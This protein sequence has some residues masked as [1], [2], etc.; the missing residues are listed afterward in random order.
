MEFGGWFDPVDDEKFVA[1]SNVNGLNTLPN[2]KFL[3]DVPFEEGERQNVCLTS[4]LRVGDAFV[5]ELNCESL[6][7][8]E[9]VEAKFV[10]KGEKFF[11]NGKMLSPGM[12]CVKSGSS[13][14]NSSSSLVFRTGAGWACLSRYS[15]LGGIGGN[16]I[17]ACDGRLRD[18]LLD[19]TF[20][21]FIPYNLTFSSL[22]E[23]MPDASNRF[24]FECPEAF[25]KLY[26]NKMVQ[27]PWSRLELIR[28]PCMTGIK[29]AIHVPIDFNTGYCECLKHGFVQHEE[30]GFCLVCG[31]DGYKKGEYAKHWGSDKYHSQIPCDPLD[32]VKDWKSR[33]LKIKYYP[34]FG[35]LN[36]YSGYVN[37]SSHISKE[38]LKNVSPISPNMRFLVETTS[39]P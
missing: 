36:C 15:E 9:G 31:F 22:D 2:V 23:K 13:V 3:S 6:C 24:R 21:G 29:N 14:C 30:L 10:S 35:E 16:K 4:F 8:S 32:T 19:K 7:D 38:H 18:N 1:L 26:N 33:D 28:N 27:S 5:E 34:C 11:I 37:E 12:Y 20:E 17:L 25:D 39:I